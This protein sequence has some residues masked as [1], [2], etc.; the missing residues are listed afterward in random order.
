MPGVSDAI[1]A[2]AETTASEQ[3]GVSVEAIRSALKGRRVARARWSAWCATLLLADVSMS[4]LARAA[5]VDPSTMRYA[6]KHHA[7]S[8]ETVRVVDVLRPLLAPLGLP[9][10]RDGV[11]MPGWQRLALASGWHAPGDCPGAA[12]DRAG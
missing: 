6:V 9:G 4:E 5:H 2:L 12:P 11:N 7:V 1:L 8:P 10:V 3:L